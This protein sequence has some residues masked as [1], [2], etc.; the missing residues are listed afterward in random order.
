MPGMVRAFVAVEVPGAVRSALSSVQDELRR[1][2]VR[3][4]WV[5]PE[6]IH[7]TLKFLGAIPV[8]HVPSVAGAMQAASAAHARFSVAVSGV[9]VFPGLRRPRVL[10]AGVSSRAAALTHLQRDLDAQLAVL[11]FPKEG[12]SFRG[13]LTIGRFKAGSDAGLSAAV[14]GGIKDAPFGELEVRELVLFQSEL[15]VDGPVY[16]VLGRAELDQK[17]A[18]EV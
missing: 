7:L 11:G 15:Q 14:L 16:T 8:G 17:K 2:N 9:G 3:A 1:R 5:R 12:R 6:N 13:H 4:R 10:W 18:E